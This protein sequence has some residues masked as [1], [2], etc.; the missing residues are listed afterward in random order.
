MTQRMKRTLIVGASLRAAAASAGAAEQVFTHTYLTETLPAGGKEIEQWVTMSE[1]KSQG[2]YKLWQTRTEFEYGITDRWQVSIYAN[3][4]KVTAQNNNSN[5][6]RA[7]YTAMGD[8]DE[9]SGGGPVTFG[10]YVPN[11]ER[12]P[13]P[14]S[15]YAKR[16]FESVSVESVYQFL[17]PY[18]DGLGLAGY[19]ELTG[20]AKTGE[21][22][23]KLLAQKNLLN[24]DLILAANLA[25]G[26]ER[27]KWSD[28]GAEKETELVLSAGASYRVA[29][30]WRV[31]LEM[32]NERGYEGAYSLANSRRDYSVW[33]A[34][35]TVHY[36][37]KIASQDFFITA[38]F[39]QQLP[40]AKAW[41]PSSQVEMVDDRIY[42]ESEKNVVRVLV[43]FSF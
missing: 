17:S 30:G 8:G 5:A 19:V 4:Y 10:S 28:V 6:S 14:S 32:R 22:E 12:L 3:A 38:G 23:L 35:P 16:G 31:G 7:D 1:K 2:L 43:G 11:L 34:G 20:G 41:S 24:D 29:N 33:Y 37:G 13:L 21:V 39:S 9:V 25:L 15:R 36:N 26:F 40:W 42:K 27:S 18:K